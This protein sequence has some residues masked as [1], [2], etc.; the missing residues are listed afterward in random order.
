MF[1][2]R[3][4]DRTLKPHF[5]LQ[6]NSALFTRSNDLEYTRITLKDRNYRRA[7]E[8][9]SRI[10]FDSVH[11][12][13]MSSLTA[14]DHAKIMLQR[15]NFASTFNS[16]F[17]DDFGWMHF[18][19]PSA[20]PKLCAEV[21]TYYDPTSN[22]TTLANSKDLLNANPL[23]PRPLS[24]FNAFLAP[25]YVESTRAR[26][27]QNSTTYVVA[28]NASSLGKFNLKNFPSSFQCYAQIF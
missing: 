20:L 1:G 3:N 24:S 21:E 17:V 16:T 25:L 2:G 6:L 12:F 27:L 5:K 23:H 19:P 26:K 28:A 13:L 15:R 7:P 11:S 4:Y 22:S 8:L 18:I 10:K 14:R 9:C